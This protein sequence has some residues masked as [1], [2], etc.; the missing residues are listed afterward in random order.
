M[1]KK[2]LRKHRELIKKIGKVKSSFNANTVR[3]HPANAYWL[4]LCADSAYESS[5]T[6]KKR[7]IDDCGFDN[8]SFIKH[9]DTQ[10]FIASTDKFVV[11]AFRG[12]EKDKIK[13]VISDLDMGLVKAYGGSVHAGFKKAYKSVEKKIDVALAEHKIQDKTLWLTGHS[14]GGALAALAAYDLK[15]KEHQINGVYTI[16]QPRVGNGSFVKKL[17]SMVPNRY[18][19]FAHK[20]DK[21][22]GIP[23]KELG[24]QHAGK[25]I[26]IISRKRLRLKYKRSK[27]VIKFLKSLVN[28]LNGHSSDGYL[29][30]IKKNFRNNP[31]PA[32]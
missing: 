27:N 1:N 21:V 4:T 24:Y 23:A 7:L 29:A 11:L 12:T 18:F 19:R 32:E 13:D 30:A 2:T 14:L 31:F 10:C 20:D 17:T 16:G 9:S 25:C 15:E 6:L 22:P 5:K 28:S 26:Y 3:Y 8:F